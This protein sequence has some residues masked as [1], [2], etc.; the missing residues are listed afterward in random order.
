MVRGSTLR[1]KVIRAALTDAELAPADW[2]ALEMHG[3]GT[4][5]G[6]PIEIG[7]A[8]AVAASS[9]GV[10]KLN[11]V[12]E[13]VLYYHCQCNVLFHA[14][15]SVRDQDVKSKHSAKWLHFKYLV[16]GRKEFGHGMP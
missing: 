3:T 10:S 7:A 14:M 6:D 1:L 12:I 2:T 13:I 5:L 9:G 4:A 16:K 11:A 8:S 15:F